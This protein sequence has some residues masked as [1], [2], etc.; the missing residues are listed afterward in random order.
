MYHSDLSLEKNYFIENWSNKNILKP[1]EISYNCIETYIYANCNKCKHFNFLVLAI[2]F[3]KLLYSDFNCCYC[4]E[5][6]LCDNINCDFCKDKRLDSNIFYKKNLISS[7]FYINLKYNLDVKLLWRCDYCY[8]S[9]EE[10]LININKN[11]IF[12]CF[13]NNNC[14]LFLDNETYNNLIKNYPDLNINDLIKKFNILKL[15]LFNFYLLY[16]ICIINNIKII[17]KKKNKYLIETY[18]LTYNNKRFYL[19]LDENAKINFKDK[20]P[21]FCYS[22]EKLYNYLKENF[23]LNIILKKF[24]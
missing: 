18:Y 3:S 1:N 23:N 13:N 15:K 19:V 24:D 11:K 7:G 16:I 4:Y 2:K 8:N 12:N 5:L 10:N 21:V 17:F 20:I 22:K 14:K 6:E 9:F